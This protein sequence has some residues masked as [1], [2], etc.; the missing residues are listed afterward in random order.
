[1]ASASDMIKRFREGRPTS[2]AERDKERNDGKVNEMWWLPKDNN[3]SNSNGLGSK[4]DNNY[5]PHYEHRYPGRDNTSSY[6]DNNDIRA[7]IAS[8]DD[9]PQT[10]G[11]RRPMGGAMR[12]RN[13]HL[14][15]LDLGS[16]WGSL[17]EDFMTSTGRDMVDRDVG[18]GIRVGT[19][20]DS[21]KSRWFEKRPGQMQEPNY[22]DNSNEFQPMWRMRGRDGP[23]DSLRLD[24]YKPAGDEFGRQSMEDMLR[25]SGSTGLK[26]LL[27]KELKLDTRNKEGSKD[28][29]NDDYD[30]Y[31][32]NSTFDTKKNT[33]EVSAAVT[34]DLNVLLKSLQDADQLKMKE[35][36]E[37]KKDGNGDHLRDGEQRTSIADVANRLEA[38][39][40]GFKILFDEKKEG[41]FSEKS[42]KERDS[43]MREAGKLEALS[44]LDDLIDRGSYSRRN[45]TQSTRN[46]LPNQNILQGIDMNVGMV[47]T[48]IDKEIMAAKDTLQQMYMI[49]RNLARGL[50]QADHFQFMENNNR[51]NKKRDYRNQDLDSRRRD[52]RDSRRRDDTDRVRDQES[53]Y[54]RKDL[55]DNYRPQSI[56][57][58]SQN[59]ETTLDEVILSLKARLSKPP[60]SATEALSLDTKP[61]T[62][63]DATLST[64]IISA[65]SITSPAP[66]PSTTI[67]PE[68]KAVETKP[69][70]NK[71]TEDTKT[72]NKDDVVKVDN[73]V[74]APSI[75]SPAPPAENKPTEDTKTENKDAAK[76]D[77]VVSAPSTTSPAP[78]ITAPAPSITAPAPSTTIE[79]E[80]KAVETKPAENKPTEDTKAENKDAA[81]GNNV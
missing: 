54:Q 43:Q 11:D 50:N 31:N 29:K 65:P 33:A 44:M 73:V 72:E 9:R 35:Y 38:E 6:R 23:G 60:V 59:I 63:I 66:V 68:F 37:R 69:V 55:N 16:S 53:S 76:A 17:G 19:K 79:P 46:Y 18:R 13:D 75:T 74:S 14:R 28:K 5:E 8:D 41:T 57:K 20:G 61:T 62:S 67:Q 39:M 70:E 36:S 71:P 4:I 7:S 10:R 34:N 77:N 30:D 25:S 2:R 26:G 80:V 52:N 58:I 15:S 42:Q 49:K 64:N 24:K 51:D 40:K 47:Q 81:K 3:N 12:S 48:A 56:S 22:V 21:D 32:Y 1:M 27:M 45:N 78:S